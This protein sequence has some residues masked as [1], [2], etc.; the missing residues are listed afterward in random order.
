MAWLLCCAIVAHDQLPNHSGLTRRPA[1]LKK[2][3]E[4]QQMNGNGHPT[5]IVIGQ[6]VACG[7]NPVY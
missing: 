1:S 4:R 5:G 7:D 2:I 6:S 3:T